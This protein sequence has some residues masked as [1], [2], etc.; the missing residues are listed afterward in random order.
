MLG[1][2]NDADANDL[3]KAYR[4]LA[5]RHHPDIN[6]DPGSTDSMARIN[7]AYWTLIDPKRRT[8]YDAML[9]AGLAEER[10]DREER[11]SRSPVSVKLHLRLGVHKTPVYGLTFVPDSSELISSS[12]DNEI[13]WWNAK[14]GAS[15]NRLKLESGSISSLLA[16]PHGLVV[17]AGTSESAISACRIERGFANPWKQASV[18]WP[19]CVAISCDG[20]RLAA[21]TV[22]HA[23]VAT[24]VYSGKQIFSRRDHAGSVTA[25]AWSKDGRFLVT[26]SSD[27]GTKLRDAE[28][29]KPLHNFQAATSTVTA[30]AFSPDNRF[31]GIAGSDLSVRVL[32]LA[33]GSLKKVLFGHS[34]PIE[35]MAFHPNG[36]LIATGGRDGTLGLWNAAEGIGQVHLEAS[37]RPILAVAF[38]ADGTKMASSGLDRTVRVWNLKVRD[39]GS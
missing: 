36:W 39:W 5:R 20:S 37:S 19:A 7:E 13:L 11:A 23:V 10:P 1:V 32:D 28:T 35:C 3:R 21:G 12:F 33:D 29:G 9:R 4:R 31:L 17:A 25:V 16:A 30:L 15:T 24:D 2:P 8:V 34:K 6:P 18:E 27:T 38:S 22:R 14:T 26:G